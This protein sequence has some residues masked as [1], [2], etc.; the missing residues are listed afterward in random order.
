MGIDYD[1][2]DFKFV[3]PRKNDWNSWI[4]ELHWLTDQT[5]TVEDAF[6]LL[7]TSLTFEVNNRK[8]SNKSKNVINIWYKV[9]KRL[10][11]YS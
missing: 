10:E 7:Q 9:Y 2:L 5:K 6:L 11:T 3:D 1:K 8:E 4:D